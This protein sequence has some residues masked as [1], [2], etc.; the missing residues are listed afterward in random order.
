MWIDQKFCGVVAELERVVDHVG[1][2]LPGVV[3]E[4]QVH[5]RRARAAVRAHLL[6]HALD[7]H[8]AV[9]P[10]SMNFIL[11]FECVMCSSPNFIVAARGPTT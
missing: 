4:R 9:E 8:V 1:D 10:I 3:E 11:R 5:E 7:R 2:G 6:L